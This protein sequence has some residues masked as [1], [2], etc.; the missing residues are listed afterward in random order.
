MIN[1]PNFATDL[2]TEFATR[3]TERI[4]EFPEFDLV[5]EVL[6]ETAGWTR[7][8]I[9]LAVPLPVDFGKVRCSERDAIIDSGTS[10]I[11]RCLSKS[12]PLY[13]ACPK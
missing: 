11:G 8:E 9:E 6:R 4:D 13:R 3:K 12:R 1:L 2:L 7:L 5:R 10:E